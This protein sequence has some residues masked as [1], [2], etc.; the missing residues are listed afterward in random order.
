MRQVVQAVSGGGVRVVDVPAPTI[1][2]AE[3]L[4]R[5]DVTIVSAGTERAVTELA[6]AGLLAKARARPDLV[7][8]VADK[9]RVEGV[10]AAAR[11]VRA[12]LGSDLPLGYSGCGRAVAVGDAVAGI[13]PG[14]LVATGGA[15]RANHA[16]F[17]AV[18]GLLCARVPDGLPAADAAFATI[19]SIA[20]H[21]LRLAEVGP[22]AKVVVIGLGLVGQLA[23]RLALASGCDVAGIDLAELP[24]ATAAGAGVLA[25]K[26]SG[27]ATTARIRSW[28]RGRGA[29]AVLI[30]AAGRAGNPVARATELA[31]DR[32]QLVVVGDVDL[33]LARTPFYE[34]E[35][36]LRFARSYGP[37]RYD[38]GYEDWGVD[39]PAGQVRWTEG[40]NQEAV[41][42]LLAS[43]RLKAADLV[44][45]T[46]EVDDAP[47]AYQLVATRSEPYLAIRFRY[48]PTDDAPAAEDLAAAP[49]DSGQVSRAL[50]ADRPRRAVGP[51]G[52]RGDGVGWVGAGAFSGSVLLPAFRAA[53]FSRF[54]T[55]A[56]AGGRTAGAFAERHGFAGV[57]ADAWEV[58]DD[59]RTGV[60]VIASAHDSHAAL[61]VAALERGRHV[62]CEKPP[63]LTLAELDQV[64][65]AAAEGGGVLMLGYNRRF[66]PAVLGGARALARRDGPLTIVYRVAAGPVPPDHWYADRRQGGRLLGEVCHFVDTCAVLAGSPVEAVTALAGREAEALLAP[67]VAVAMR[68]ADGTLSTIAYSSARPADAGKEA[69]EAVAGG[70]HLRIDDFR[71]LVVNGHVS[72]RGPQDKGHRAAVEHF[73]SLCLAA[74][75]PTGSGDPIGPGGELRLT[76][77][78]LASSRATLTAAVALG[79]GAPADLAATGGEPGTHPGVPAPRPALDQVPPSVSEA[80]R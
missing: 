21:G 54:T 24:L 38:R 8:K 63:A 10:G 31:R 49:G 9:A 14:D 57:A 64:E 36:S 75:G 45:H 50:A 56:S 39:Y 44:T 4:V 12:R 17:Q 55:V 19:A 52:G 34:R 33:N 1:G 25:L 78:L 32:A 30:C 59:D 35:L 62:W 77:Q 65:R 37:G 47:A 5:T 48:P 43:G 28:S 20:L 3:V 16:D 73:R 80:G 29:D 70:D 61:T 11:S 26:E 72:W 41:L 76:A 46:F 60:V 18:P 74:D 66:S 27:P 71:R 40:R 79:L 69:V 53:G 2:P 68:H 7:R 22:G 6:R 23:A 13:R 51:A 42:D 58:I 15:G 67:D